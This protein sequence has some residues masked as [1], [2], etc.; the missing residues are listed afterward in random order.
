MTGSL[1]TQAEIRKRS[2]DSGGTAL[3]H[4]RWIASPMLEQKPARQQRFA[5]APAGRIPLNSRAS[6][7]VNKRD[8]NPVF[9]KPLWLVVAFSAAVS[10]LSA[11]ETQKSPEK[12]KVD[13]P[14]PSGPQTDGAYRKVILDTDREVDGRWQD[15]V[16]DPME[17]TVA[18]D[19]RVFWAE[20]AGA[21]KMWKPESKT[22]V[23]IARLK[24][25]D[26][27]EDGLIG[28]TLDPNFAKNGWVYLNHSI[29]ETTKD[30]QGHK[31][32]IIRVSRF[33]LA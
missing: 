31:A 6:V 24:V 13:S 2:R 10:S 14:T 3:P 25:F 18:P 30:A 11:A 26:G 7:P 4:G 9:L 12:P 27:L 28:I 32:G 21:V 17:L 16:K 19:G 23:E 8:M 20:R 33:T 5:V 15:T 22:T 29:P 1:E